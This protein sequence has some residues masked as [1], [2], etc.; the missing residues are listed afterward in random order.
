[1]NRSVGKPF[2][3]E[4]SPAEPS[5][6]QPLG[7][8]ERRSTDRRSAD[9]FFNKFLGGQPYLCRTV[10]VSERGALVETFAEP[11]WPAGRFPLELRVPESRQTLWL[12]A[13][14][15]RRVGRHQALEFVSMSVAAQQHLK[16]WLDR[17][18]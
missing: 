5:G 10:D 18:A 2:C 11:E 4:P 3:A 9:L 15:V 7:A 16:R 12:W 14:C 8:E 13:R 1:M 6:V 17:A